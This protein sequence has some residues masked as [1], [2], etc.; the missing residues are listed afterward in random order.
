MMAMLNDYGCRS[1]L[2][3]LCV[4]LFT[5]ELVSALMTFYKAEMVTATTL[6]AQEKHERPWI[7]FS[8]KYLMRQ[9]QTNEVR[10]AESLL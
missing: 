10:R 3:F 1:L 5:Y 2:V 4:S 7:C 6:E 8:S 9:S